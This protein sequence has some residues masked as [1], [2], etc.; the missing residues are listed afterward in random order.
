MHLREWKLM[1]KKTNYT[2]DKLQS[3]LR[4]WSVFGFAAFALILVV[5]CSGNGTDGKGVEDD[6][7]GDYGKA[8]SFYDPTVHSIGLGEAVNLSTSVTDDRLYHGFDFELTAPATVSL[9]TDELRGY[10]RVD[11]VIYLYRRSETGWGRYIA[12][13]DDIS[14]DNL[15]SRLSELE[16]AA[17]SYRLLVKPYSRRDRGWFVLRTSCDGTGCRPSGEVPSSRCR[18]GIHYGQFLE[19]PTFDTT[20]DVTVY[21]PADMSA[22]EQAQLIQVLADYTGSTPTIEEAFEYIDFSELNL[23]ERRDRFTGESYRS[24]EYGLGENSYGAIFPADETVVVATIGDGDFYGCKVDA[25]PGVAPG[26]QCIAEYACT[27]E[28]EDCSCRD[29]LVCEGVSEGVGICVF[30]GVS[31][32]YGSCETDG[33][34]VEHGVCIG[35]TWG[36]GNAFCVEYWMR[37]TFEAEGL[38][39]IP[40]LG[41]REVTFHARGLATVSIDVVPDV[42][43]NHPAP[44]QLYVTLANPFGTTSV[45][46]D[47][48]NPDNASAVVR[49]GGLFLS[50]PVG[51]PSDEVANGI[52]TLR[53]EDRVAG[54]K[55]RTW[56]GGDLTISSQWD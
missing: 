45:V 33:D 22:I 35:T 42:G 56:Y 4:N 48:E 28:P 39:P 27:T 18:F 31:D 11:T 15:Y 50:R 38:G 40:D 32:A 2:A 6:P 21:S 12:K 43:I 13:N 7:L 8:D 16:L 44:S 30:R 9:A 17:G 23:T 49:D 19:E 26:D 25:G 52:W 20:R 24:V 41:A 54:L 1:K 5:S 34:C 3:N 10:D 37:G 14:Y 46:F 29:G 47:G 51:F 55:G 36:P 53:I